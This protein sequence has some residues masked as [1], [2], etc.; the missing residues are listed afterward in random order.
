MEERQ[1]NNVNEV[2]MTGENFRNSLRNQKKKY[3]EKNVADVTG[4]MIRAGIQQKDKLLKKCHCLNYFTI[5]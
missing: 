4:Y 3:L 2:L 1:K 5:C